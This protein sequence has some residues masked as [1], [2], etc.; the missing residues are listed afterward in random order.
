MEC[1]VCWG[2]GLLLGA[3][4]PLCGSGTAACLPASSAA[5][6]V[7]RCAC[8]G[9]SD[10]TSLAAQ[11]RAE[12]LEPQAAFWRHEHRLRKPG[13]TW[14]LTGHSRALVRSG[15]CVK[16]LN[17]FFDAGVAWKSENVNPSVIAV[18]HTHIDHCNALPML[19]RTE[20][21]PVILAPRNHLPALKE[22]A[23]MT[24][25]VKKA[26]W[27]P[28]AEATPVRQGDAWKGPVTGIGDLAQV[29]NRSVGR[30]W[31]G[32]V[33]GDELSLDLPKLTPGLSLHVVR[34]FHTL[35]DVGFVLCE[36]SKS[37]VGVDAESEAKY[38]EVQRQIQAHK[39]AGRKKEAGLL[40]RSIGEMQKSGQIRQVT[41][42]A[43]RLA[44]LC[45]TT[46]QVFGRCAACQTGEACLFKGDYT[47]ACM[48]EEE[49]ELQAKLIFQCNTVIVECSF[50]AI[51]MDEAAA[52]A[53]AIKRGHVAWS[54]L[55]PYVEAHP[56]TQFI[57]VH[58]S[59]RYKDAEI[60][61]HFKDMIKIGGPTNVL[62]WL[63]D[64]LVDLSSV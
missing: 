62:L 10:A 7:D 44:Y 38:K 8:F 4:C 18:T 9:C 12:R 22:M 39:D 46:V 49:H 51:G 52:E 24:W 34:C 57:L 29:G 28:T 40:G 32:A 50:L 17:M 36:S 30:R 3:A 13:A 1:P 33:P 64:G 23:A 15:F 31:L 35:E 60:S 27:Q 2:S 43:P 5:A 11:L 19:L 48:S 54:Q 25:S 63:D 55:K 58:F 37:L 26:D 47:A 42:T 53:E 61:A 56:E 6:L 41:A 21:S 45:D 14:T 16:E 59:K 20:A